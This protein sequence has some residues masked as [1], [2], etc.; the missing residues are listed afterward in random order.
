MNVKNEVAKRIND[1]LDFDMHKL[2]KDCGEFKS[3]PEWCLLG[4]K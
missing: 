2:K 1:K 4:L 3:I